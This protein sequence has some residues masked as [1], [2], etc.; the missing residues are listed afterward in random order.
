MSSRFLAPFEKQRNRPNLRSR[1]SP[2]IIVSGIADDDLR[3]ISRRQ[4]AGESESAIAFVT[5]SETAHTIL[6]HSKWLN[7]V[8]PEE[9]GAGNLP[10][11][12]TVLRLCSVC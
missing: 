8:G 6:S 5:V 10:V 11:A 9:A 2:P 7:S 3:F 1:R 4:R 12:T